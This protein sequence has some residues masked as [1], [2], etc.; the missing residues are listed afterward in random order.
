MV[1][2]FPG[3]VPTFVGMV[4][5]FVGI[6]CT[7]AKSF[8]GSAE[9]FRRSSAWFLGT[10]TWLWGTSAWFRRSAEWFWRSSDRI[11]PSRNQSGER[12]NRRSQAPAR[13]CGGSGRPFPSHAPACGAGGTQTGRRHAWPGGL[14]ARPGRQKHLGGRLHRRLP[15]QTANPTT[16]NIA[17]CNATI[18]S[19]PVPQK[20]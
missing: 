12:R 15:L 11:L 16:E 20:P 1:L 7:S 4:P 10:S 9:W 18:T 17:P 13:C 5:G 6:G 8:R 19:P 3:F 14:A 2:P